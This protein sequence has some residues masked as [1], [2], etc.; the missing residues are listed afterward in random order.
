[1]VGSGSHYIRTAVKVIMCTERTSACPKCLTDKK[2]QV[3]SDINCSKT[4]T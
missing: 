2:A 4:S 1:M 3:K